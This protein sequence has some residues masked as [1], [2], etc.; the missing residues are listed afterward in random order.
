MKPE[1]FDPLYALAVF[2]LMGVITSALRALPFFAARW[3]RHSS[4][5]AR[6]GRFLPPAIMVLLLL[7]VLAGLAALGAAQRVWQHGGVCGFA[8]AAIASTRAASEV[9]EIATL[10]YMRNHTKQNGHPKADGRCSCTNS[11]RIQRRTA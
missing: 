5:V 1:G 3:L 6:L 4:V 9:P 10:P 11:E 7:H 2:L 8:D